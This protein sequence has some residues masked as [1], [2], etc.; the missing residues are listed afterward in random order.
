MGYYTSEKKT[1]L[2]AVRLTPSDHAAIKKLIERSRTRRYYHRVISVSEVI[3]KA[4]D[5]FLHGN[6]KHRE[7]MQKNILEAEKE[8]NPKSKKVIPWDP[9]V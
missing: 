6:S 3:Q 8:A 7:E 4:T 2:I 9:R 1:K 5:D